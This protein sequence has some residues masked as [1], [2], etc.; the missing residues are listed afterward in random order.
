MSKVKG[1][2]WYRMLDSFEDV[3]SFWTMIQEE[4]DATVM[5]VQGEGPTATDD[6]DGAVTE[7]SEEAISSRKINL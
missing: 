7:D 3:T 5:F 1:K 2:S 4:S 6:C